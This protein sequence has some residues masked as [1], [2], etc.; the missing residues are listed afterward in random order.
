MMLSLEILAALTGLVSVFLLTKQNIWAWPTGMVSVAAATIVFYDSFLYSDMLLHIYYFG[1]N[2]Y[3]WIHWSRKTEDQAGLPVTT[4]SFIHNVK[5]VVI[6]LAGTILWG[7]TMSMNTDASFPYG[8]AFTTV[9][10]LVAMWLMAQKRLENWAYWFVIDIAAITI[11]ALKG[12]Y[13]FS[14][15]YFV[16]L[17]LC[18]IGFKDWKRSMNS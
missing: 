11:Y 17:I 2:L 6:A 3:G 4:I 1:M 14:G 18:V 13:L 8:D 15:Q 5:W 16:F 10:S 12:L 9:A 7:W